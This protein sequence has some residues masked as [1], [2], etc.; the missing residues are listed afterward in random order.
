LTMSQASSS[1]TGSIPPGTPRHHHVAHVGHATD[2]ASPGRVA[3][4]GDP[5]NKTRKKKQGLQVDAWV[6]CSSHNKATGSVVG[7]LVRRRS[8]ESCC[9]V[10]AKK[11]ERVVCFTKESKQKNKTRKKERKGKEGKER[12]RKR[13]G[14]RKEEKGRERKRGKKEKKGKKICLLHVDV[15]RV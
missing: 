9:A 13:K 11:K 4:E 1:L 6:I 5:V 14:K 15:Q 12:E 10:A 3:A 2:S 7:L 8:S